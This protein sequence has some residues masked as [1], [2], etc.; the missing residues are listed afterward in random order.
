MTP[1]LWVVTLL[2]L[3]VL[4]WAIIIYIIVKAVKLVRGFYK[5]LEEINKKLGDLS[6]NQDRNFK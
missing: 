3:E 1:I 2:V 5:N 6:R 4:K